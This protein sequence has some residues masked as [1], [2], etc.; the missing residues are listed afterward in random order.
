MSHASIPKTETVRIFAMSE[1]TLTV[2]GQVIVPREIRNRLGLKSGDKVAFTM[3]SD[4]TVVVRPKTRRLTDLVGSLTRRGQ[5]SALV[6]EMDP[7]KR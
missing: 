6:E 2:K 3:L 7:F 4:G 5:P 1:A